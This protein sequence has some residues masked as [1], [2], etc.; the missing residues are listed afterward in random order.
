[1]GRGSGLDRSSRGYFGRERDGVDQNFSSLKLTIP[2]FQGKSDPD[3]Y[4]QWERKLELVFDYHYYSKKKKV[5]LAVEAFIDYA[6]TWW[7]QFVLT[8]RRCGEPP[9]DDWE[10][11]KA[12]MRK[13]FVPAHYYRELKMQSSRQVTK[14][15]ERSSPSWESQMSYPTSMVRESV[16]KPKREKSKTEQQFKTKRG[17]CPS[18]QFVNLW[19][20]IEDEST[21]EKKIIYVSPPQRNDNIEIPMEEN[22]QDIVESIGAK[23][24][25]MQDDIVELQPMEDEKC[26][27]APPLEEEMEAVPTEMLH[28]S[29]IQRLDTL[30]TRATKY[31]CSYT[32]QWLQ[33]GVFCDVVQRCVKMLHDKELEDAKAY[34]FKD[35]IRAVNGE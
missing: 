34:E 15:E 3:A 29:S 9:I 22:V 13:R 23:I 11:M 31:P 14:S 7:D 16:Q 10:S 24:E 18:K 30:G 1:M 5:K 20:N 12:V 8:R 28:P 35:I 21:N 6:I 4:I 26:I 19:S 32:F 33:D 25:G 2:S 27:T 17:E